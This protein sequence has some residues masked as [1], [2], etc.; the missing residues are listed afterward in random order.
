MHLCL[1]QQDRVALETGDL[2][3]HEC[4]DMVAD[5]HGAA[6]AGVQPPAVCGRELGDFAIIAG[7]ASADA[8]VGTHE[9]GDE[10]SRRLVVECLRRAEL[11]EAAA[12]HH[13][14]VIGEHQRLGLVVRDVDEGGAERGL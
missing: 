3:P 4:L 14:H 5:R 1:R 12:V 2:R 13:R 10:C 9:T 7:E 6:L 8:V 11:L